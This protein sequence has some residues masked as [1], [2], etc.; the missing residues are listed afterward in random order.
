[1]RNVGQQDISWITSAEMK[2]M[3]R[4]AKYTWQ[5]FKTNEDILSELIIN[6]IVKKIQNFRNKWIQHVRRMDRDRLPHL[7]MK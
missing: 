6:P 5:D 7:A 2:F 1:M 3:R 4:A